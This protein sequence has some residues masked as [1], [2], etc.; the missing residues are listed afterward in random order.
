MNGWSLARAQALTRASLPE[1]RPSLTDAPWLTT[2]MSRRAY[3]RQSLARALYEDKHDVERKID[4]LFPAISSYLEQH[5]P[6]VKFSGILPESTGRNGEMMQPGVKTGWLMILQ[7]K[8][9]SQSWKQLNR[10]LQNLRTGRRMKLRK[11]YPCICQ[12]L[13]KGA[14]N[15]VGCRA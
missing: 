2:V 14:K 8:S 3:T 5:M 6:Q 13:R 7:K 12:P 1:A 9:V 15:E 11:S 10:A 4:E